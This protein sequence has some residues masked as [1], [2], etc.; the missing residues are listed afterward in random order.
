MHQTDVERAQDLMSQK[1]A[2]N[3]A[4]FR[5]MTA[6]LEQK[7]MAWMEEQHIDVEKSK[8]TLREKQK[9]SEVAIRAE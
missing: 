2:Q 7:K 4:N 1:E 8:A 6:E 3:Q 9:E 5:A